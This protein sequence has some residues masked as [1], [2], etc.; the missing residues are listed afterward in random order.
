MVPKE[1]WATILIRAALIESDIQLACDDPS[2]PEMDNVNPSTKEEVKVK[3]DGEIDIQGAITG[4]PCAY[5]V[6]TMHETHE[7]FDTLVLRQSGVSTDTVSPPGI[8]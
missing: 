3:G 5:I 2:F 1:H 4:H 7:A 6:C 8:Q